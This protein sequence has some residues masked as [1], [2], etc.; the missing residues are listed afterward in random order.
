VSGSGARWCFEGCLR[1]QKTGLGFN[2]ENSHQVG[3][4]V[5]DHKVRVCGVD[6]SFMG[7]RCVL[8]GGIG[9]RCGEGEREGL[10]SFDTA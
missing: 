2:A 9:A 8:T 4:Q 1:S 7:M 10:E 3:S 5:R 6:E